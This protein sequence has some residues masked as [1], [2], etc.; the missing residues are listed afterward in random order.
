MKASTR[1]LQI[2]SIAL[3]L[4]ACTDQEAE[5]L[6]A[7]TKATYDKR[8]GRLI[9][10]TSDA[11][12]NGRIDTWIEM[13]GSRPLRSR[14]D[15]DEDGRIDRW[16]YYDPQGRL[17]KVGFSRSGA[18]TPDAWAYSDARGNLERVEISSTK[19]ESKIDR[20]E[21]YEINRSSAGLLGPM[22]SAEEDSNGDEKPDRWETYQYGTI[23][24]LAFDEDFD[25]RPDRRLT[26]SDSVLTL[27]ETEPDA[28]GRYTK[29]VDVDQ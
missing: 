4:T 12:H 23:R 7:T 11:N 28:A 5:R 18:A 20:W 2:G 27:I 24:T 8:T 25:G 13:D 17:V 15:R 6:R 1:G 3:L 21:H 16:E 9:E 19:D 26:Y 22:V 29:R 14:T 10:L